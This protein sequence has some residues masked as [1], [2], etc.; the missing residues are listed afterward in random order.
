MLDGVDVHDAGENLILTGATE[1]IVNYVL[2]EMQKEGALNVKKAVKVGSKWVGSTSNPALALCSVEHVGYVIWIRG[3]SESAILTRSHEFRERGALVASPPRQDGDQWEM[4]LEN[5][6][7]RL[8][9]GTI[10]G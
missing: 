6:G 4:S 8:R 7:D 10:A 2:S 1:E 5:I 3:P 9:I